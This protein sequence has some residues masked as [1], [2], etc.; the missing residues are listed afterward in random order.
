MLVIIFTPPPIWFLYTPLSVHI[1]VYIL[2]S[3]PYQIFCNWN[4]PYLLL[5]LGMRQDWTFYSISYFGLS[6]EKRKYFLDRNL[7]LLNHN[8]IY[9]FGYISKLD[10]CKTWTR[11][12]VKTFHSERTRPLRALLNNAIFFLR[13][14]SAL[15]VLKQR[16]CKNIL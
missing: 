8:T 4:R 9:K 6:S 15:N 13:E 1:I 3:S 7:Y 5:C 2:T 11:E 12:Q 10:C 14:K 16:I